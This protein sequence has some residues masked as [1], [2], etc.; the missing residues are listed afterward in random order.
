[1]PPASARMPPPSVRPATMST[2]SSIRP[3][4]SV[5]RPT[6][7]RSEI[8]VTLGRPVGQQVEQRAPPPACGHVDRRHEGVR[9]AGEGARVDDEQ[10]I[11][12]AAAPVD[13][14]PDAG[15]RRLQVAAEHVEGQR[16]AQPDA[17]AL[18]RSP[19]RSR[20]GAARHS[21][22]ATRRPATSSVPSGTRL[23]IGEAAVAAD[24]PGD[25]VR[26][27]DLGDR[28][29]GDAHHPR[30]QAGQELL[31]AA[32]P[33]SRPGSARSTSRCCGWMSIR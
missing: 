10:E 30:A 19:R 3:S 17:V 18:R 9:G 6:S 14:A 5:A 29:A 32:C 13:L 26:D 15:D 20:P 12:P 16:V 2:A 8:G 25:I 28:P 21:R 27:L 23:G 1:M 31:Q 33:G 22:P 4:T 24:R 7:S 11:E